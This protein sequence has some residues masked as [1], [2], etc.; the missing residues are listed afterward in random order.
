MNKIQDTLKAF[1]K[2]Y[3]KICGE[4]GG[5]NPPTGEIEMSVFLDRLKLDFRDSEKEIAKALEDTRE[6][7]YQEGREEAIMGFAIWAQ[8]SIGKPADEILKAYG[9][10]LKGEDDK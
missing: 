6:E 10:F 8:V 1:D 7:A 9:E 2:L 5:Y 3:K 4:L